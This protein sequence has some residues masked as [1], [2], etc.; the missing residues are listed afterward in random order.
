ME[1]TAECE[2][3]AN[4]WRVRVPELDNLLIPTKRLDVATEHIK[5]LI[6]EARGIDRSEIIVK[7]DTNLPGIMC[8][9]AQAQKKMSDARKM[10]EQAS[11][12]VRDVVSRLRS[13]GWSM[14]DIAVVLGIS[15]QRVAQLVES[16]ACPK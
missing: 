5:D 7:I 15:A 14:R 2:R 11:K 16:T 3:R 13:E 1:V 6:H 8:D 9:L 12:E 10:Q 4:A